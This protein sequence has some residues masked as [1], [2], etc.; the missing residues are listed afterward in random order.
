MNCALC[1]TKVPDEKIMF[2]DECD[3]CGGDLHICLNCSFYDPNVSKQCREPA[4]PE[5]VLD[6]EPKNLCEYFNKLAAGHG[7]AGESAGDAARRKLDGL[8]K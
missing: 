2:Q 1:K 4:I 8:F 7:Q 5:V 6:K 3:H